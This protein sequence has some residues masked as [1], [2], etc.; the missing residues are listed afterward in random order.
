[1]D[2]T[3]N[4]L[5][6]FWRDIGSE[7]RFRKDEALDAEIRERFLDLHRRAADGGLDDWLEHADSALAL[8]ILLDQFPRN[9]FRGSA[10]AFA[11]DELALRHSIGAIE[12]GQHLAADRSLFFF[13]FLPFMHCERI[14]EQEQCVFL[15]H[16]HPSSEILPHA[17]THRDIIRRFGRFPHRN[18]ALGRSTTAS[19]AAFLAAGGFSG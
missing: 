13:F 2:V 8:V 9:M 1:M 5:L 3:S 17:R 6:Q 16:A 11:T 7:R 4:S 12:K 10:E 14:A 19:E 18:T 15:A